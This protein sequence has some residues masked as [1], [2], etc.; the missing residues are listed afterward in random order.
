MQVEAALRKQLQ[1]GLRDQ[2]AVSETDQKIGAGR[3]EPRPKRIPIMGR[4]EF[5]QWGHGVAE[6]RPQSK[7]SP[8]AAAQGTEAEALAGK[9]ARHDHGS[10]AMAVICPA[11]K[12]GRGDG[13]NLGDEYGRE[14]VLHAELRLDMVAAAPASAPS[15]RHRD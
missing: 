15:G 8:Q 6:M 2:F 1:H 11:R 13:R 7:P 10:N 14:R 3:A 12:H 9:W 4:A 5:D